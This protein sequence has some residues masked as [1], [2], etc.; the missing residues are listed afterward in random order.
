MLMASELAITTNHLVVISFEA[1]ILGSDGTTIAYLI[2]NSHTAPEIWESK[3]EQVHTY[4]VIPV[5]RTY[6]YSPQVGA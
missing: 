6:Y 2:S 3:T 1:R 5:R 4:R